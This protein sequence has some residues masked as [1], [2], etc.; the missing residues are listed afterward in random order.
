V[1]VHRRPLLDQWK[2]QLALFF[3]IDQSAIGEIGRGNRRPRGVSMWPCSRASPG[4]MAWTIGWPLT[5][6]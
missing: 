2:A 1:L 4:R 3:G 6:R 5:A